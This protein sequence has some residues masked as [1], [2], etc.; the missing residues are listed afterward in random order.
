MGRDGYFDSRS[1]D[2]EENEEIEERENI[3]Q[4]KKQELEEFG[5]L[6]GVEEDEKAKELEDLSAW[7]KW[8]NDWKVKTKEKEKEIREVEKSLYDCEEYHPER[9]QIATGKAYETALKA[10]DKA[11]KR[12]RNW[13]SAFMEILEIGDLLNSSCRNA[14]DRDQERVSQDTGRFVRRSQVLYREAPSTLRSSQGFRGKNRQSDTR[15]AIPCS[16]MGKNLH[17]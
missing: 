15:L 17:L 4:Q 10:H 1:L 14:A 5:K 11:E 12:A 16:D 8:N 13:E 3:I 9:K 7:R 6:Q 2:E